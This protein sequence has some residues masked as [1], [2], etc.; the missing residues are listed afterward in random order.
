MSAFTIPGLL[1]AV[2]VSLHVATIAI[3]AL[4]CRT[5]ARRRSA[6]VEPMPPATIVRPVSGLDFMLDE[7]LATTFG[8]DHPDYQIL[9][10]A[11]SESDAAV[12]IVRALIAR[13]PHAN[14]RL[15]IGNDPISENPKLNNVAKGW[16]E[17]RNDFI[18][19]IDSN[20]LLPADYLQRCFAAW[21]ERAGLVSAPPA[22]SHVAN[23]AAEVEA[24]FLNAYQARWQYAANAIGLGF[25]QGKN[26]FFRRDMLRAAGGVRALAS[27][28]AEDAAAT[29][30]VRAQGLHVR[31]ASGPFAQPLGVR[32]WL[33]VW[34]RQTRWSRLGRMSFPAF[35]AL[36]IFA[37]VVPPTIA[38]LWWA[39]AT[40]RDIAATIAILWLSWF[41]L[42]WALA[43]TAGWPSSL[44][45]IAASIARDLMLPLIWLQGWRN[46]GFVWRGH[47]MARPEALRPRS[48]A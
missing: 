1:L 28:L 22:G 36:E 26:L 23:L 21:D 2:L 37:G 29:K 47:T 25:A 30:I 11:A 43:R 24:A 13:H 7:T 31:L 17:A 45:M 20:V 40:H 16:R 33:N 38:A 41:G 44:R 46:R 32:D 34:N 8:L 4:T 5:S 9:F 15:L 10:C 42:E 6:N 14:A 27:E 39:L 12:P 35:F 3:A 48:T 18:V 19:M